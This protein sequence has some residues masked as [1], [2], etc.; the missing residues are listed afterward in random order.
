MNGPLPIPACPVCGNRAY[1]LHDAGSAGICECSTCRT[2]F[3]VEDPGHLYVFIAQEDDGSVHSSGLV[4][5]VPVALAVE[6]LDAPR[7]CLAAPPGVRRRMTE[8]DPSAPFI[9][10]CRRPRDHDG[11][12]RGCFSASTCHPAHGSNFNQFSE[13]PR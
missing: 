5:W 1:L 8:V 12:H 7:G 3:D 13:W 4:G 6:H 2:H 11:P 10:L 9:G